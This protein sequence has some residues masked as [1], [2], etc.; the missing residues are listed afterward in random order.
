MRDDTKNGFVADLERASCR[1]EDIAMATRG[2]RS[3]NLQVLLRMRRMYVAS[4]RLDFHYG[5]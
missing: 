4:I 5:T 2:A 3:L 1:F